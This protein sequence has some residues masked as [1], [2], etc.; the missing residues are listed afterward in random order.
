MLYNDFK[1]LSFTEKRYKVEQMTDPFLECDTSE[2]EYL[3]SNI[4]NSRDEREYEYWIK[5][6]GIFEDSYR[7]YRDEKIMTV[8]LSLRAKNALMRNGIKTVGQLIDNRFILHT[9]RSVG[10][11][12]H[13]EVKKLLEIYGY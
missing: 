7:N 13:A 10:A 3:L 8:K 5:E 6:L 2:R 12:T 11:K 4:M 9:M 1:K